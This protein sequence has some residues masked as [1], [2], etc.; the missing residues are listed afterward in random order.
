[1]EAEVLEIPADP[2]QAAPENSYGTAVRPKPKRNYVW[3]WVLF[4]LTVIVLCSAAVAATVLNVRLE[5]GE[6]GWSLRLPE[7]NSSAGSGLVRDL[8]VS[9]SAGE[10]Q[11]FRPDPDNSIQLHLSQGGSEARTDSAA[12]LYQ[13]VS[14]SVVCL[15]VP[16]YYG[17]VSLTGV[18]LSE[19]GYLL[20]AASELGGAT[21]FNVIF[22]D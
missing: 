20:T 1:M 18:V 9:G 21:E 8:P 15:E 7:R 6:N 11:T 17:T 2:A 14:P 4:G 3:F 16:T 5:R 13:A 19:D 12:D 10:T 22:S